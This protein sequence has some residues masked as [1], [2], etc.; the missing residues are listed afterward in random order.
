M[1]MV[2]KQVKY[3]LVKSNRYLN[4]VDALFN[5]IVLS[6]ACLRGIVTG[7]FFLLSSPNGWQ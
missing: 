7:I 3:I 5:C 4:Y 6:V 1:L 2:R